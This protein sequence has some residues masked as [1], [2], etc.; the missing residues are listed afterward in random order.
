MESSS[1]LNDRLT[2]EGMLQ[3]IDSSQG[4]AVDVRTILDIKDQDIKDENLRSQ[5]SRIEN[6]SVAGD[7]KLKDYFS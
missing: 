4:K 3:V 1:D 2:L 7:A 6:Q 5:L